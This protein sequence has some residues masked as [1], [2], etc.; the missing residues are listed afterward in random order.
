MSKKIC[1]LIT[2]AVSFN[3]LCRG[4]LEYIRD[5]SDFDITLICGGSKEQLDILR[6]RK[7]GK[8]IDAKM[9]RKPS[10]FRD[11]RSLSFLIYYLTSNR[12]DLVVYSTPKALL[13]G[14][15]A[16]FLSGQKKR[17]AVVHGR[18]YENF[19]GVKKQIFQNF[20]KFSFAISDKVV[21]VSTSL[22]QNYIDE[23]IIHEKNTNVLG[24]GSFNGVS[25]EFFRPVDIEEKAKL[26]KNMK[27]SSDSFLICVVGRICV[28]KGIKDIQELL[29]FLTNENIKVIF[30]G[31]FED[32]ASK[33]IVEK[34]VDSKQGYYIPYTSKI[35]E[36]FQCSD[37]HLFMSHREG[38]GNV[39]IEAASCGVPTFAYDVVGIKDSVNEGVSGKKFVFK[40]IENIAK[41]INKAASNPN[42]KLEYKLARDWSIENFDQKIVWQNYLDF[43]S[44]NV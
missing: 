23:K 16:G 17:V 35:Y 18:V 21:F 5:N 15:I 42:F 8:V 14:S 7:V 4:Q 29:K 3:V 10:L 24:R 22:L 37:L 6:A 28:D 9:L 32:E 39:A 11:I 44:K 34:V 1:F 26:R 38:F 2:D 43:Y 13:L 36:I 25:T 27:I 20:D 33:I 30:V 31:A 12:F 19:K 40:D 41:E